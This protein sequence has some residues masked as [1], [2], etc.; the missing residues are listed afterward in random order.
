MKTNRF[1]DIVE[2]YNSLNYTQ[3]NVFSNLIFGEISNLSRMMK[4]FELSKNFKSEFV[5][6][7]PS[8]VTSELVEN[9]FITLG[10]NSTSFKFTSKTHEYLQIGVGDCVSI[11]FDQVN[12]K[13]WLYK[14]KNGY[15]VSANSVSK[16]TGEVTGYC[17]NNKEAKDELR[18][19]YDLDT[20]K[21]YRFCLRRTS[22]VPEQIKSES[23]DFFELH[24]PYIST[25]GVKKIKGS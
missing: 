16:H 7:T 2:L 10:R 9:P 5:K 12:K 24:D 15:T 14:S 1:D 17:F 13:A 19:I 6:I 22:I 4:I 25:L 23:N 21:T 8:Y 18:K 3:K 11:T 20:K